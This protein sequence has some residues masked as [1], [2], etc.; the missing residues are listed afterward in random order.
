M[1]TIT[2]NL[3][4]FDYDDSKPSDINPNMNIIIYIIDMI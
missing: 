3:I 2:I 4:R 1:D